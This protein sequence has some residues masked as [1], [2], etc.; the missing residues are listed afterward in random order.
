[1]RRLRRSA[2]CSVHRLSIDRL[3]ENPELAWNM[4]ENGRR[5]VHEKYNWDIEERK[6]LSLYEEL[7]SRP[8]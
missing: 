1:M 2:R 3:V 7:L 5:A 6:L 8:V 4:G